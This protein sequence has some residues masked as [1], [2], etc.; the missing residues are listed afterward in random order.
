MFLCFDFQVGNL[1]V[2]VPPDIIDSGEGQVSDVLAPEGGVVQ[3]RC[4]ARG[5]PLPHITWR[6]EDSHDIIIR[7]G[8]RTKR[9]YK[10][11]YLLDLNLCGQNKQSIQNHII[12]Y[13]KW[14]FCILC[15][16]STT[17]DIH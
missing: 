9:T 7:D 8:Q 2:V 13:M 16:H 12:D 1:N 5:H 6:R 14:K 4:R 11:L 3:L 10:Y 17:F 15:L